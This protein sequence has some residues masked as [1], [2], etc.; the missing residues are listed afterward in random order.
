MRE[1]ISWVPATAAVPRQAQRTHGGRIGSVCDVTPRGRACHHRA[2]MV[3]SIGLHVLRVRD[4]GRHKSPRCN[5]I[6]HDTLRMSY[7]S[8]YMCICSIC[9]CIC[10]ICICFKFKFHYWP[11]VGIAP[12]QYQQYKDRS[13]KVYML[14]PPFSS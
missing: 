14:A 12:A 10:S 3:R 13:G 8:I 2:R 1:S 6:R 5:M 7:V 9:M 4:F 11:L